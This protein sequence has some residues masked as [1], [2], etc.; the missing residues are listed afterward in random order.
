MTTT[1]PLEHRI[2]VGSRVYHMTTWYRWVNYIQRGM[3]SLPKILL[4]RT[5]PK[6][7]LGA[8]KNDQDLINQLGT[9]LDKNYVVCGAVKDFSDWKE[10][11]LYNRL[12]NHVCRDFD[13]S[14]VVLSFILE[15]GE[16]VYVREHAHWSPKRFTELCGKNLFR[17]LNSEEVPSDD[18]IKLFHSQQRLFLASSTPIKDYDGSF[19]LPEIWVPYAIPLDKITLEE[20]IR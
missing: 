16:N 20:E 4:P 14:L 10:H 18:E 15:T 12:K 8:S 9:F 1:Q 13:Q 7:E 6:E 17:F 11:G 19:Q 3:R 5:N 2:D